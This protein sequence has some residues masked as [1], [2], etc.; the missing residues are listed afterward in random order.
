MFKYVT[1]VIIK[2]AFCVYIRFERRMKILIVDD[3]ARM[4]ELMRTFLKNVTAK[5][6]ECDDGGE[7]LVSYA[8]FHPDLVLM[9]WEMKQ[10]DGITAMRQIINIYPEANIVLVTQYDDDEL[11]SAAHEAGANGFVLKDDLQPIYQYCM[12]PGNRIRRL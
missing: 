11:K 6:C 7:A 10:M 12:A 1:N 4:R 9:D 2:R 5:F 3:N 8:N